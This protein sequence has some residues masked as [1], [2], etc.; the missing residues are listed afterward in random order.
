MVTAGGRAILSLFIIIIVSF[1]VGCGRASKKAIGEQATDGSSFSNP[2]PENVVQSEQRVLPPKVIEVNGIS[3]EVDIA[4]TPQE[5][6]QG[7]SGRSWLREGSGMLFLYDQPLIPAFWMK[8]ML[9]SI[10]IV[11][12]RGGK[13]IDVSENLPIPRPRQERAEL[14][15]YAPRE[16]ITEVLEVPAG[17][18]MRQNIKIGSAVVMPSI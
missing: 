6:S 4:R 17:W 15:T 14:P 12:I 10:D 9:F 1:F 5:K 18:V 8:D 16:P 2:K 13:V 3:L 7:L 11:W